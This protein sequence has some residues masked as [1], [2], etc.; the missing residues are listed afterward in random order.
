MT[1]TIRFVTL[2]CT[3][4]APMFA[5]PTLSFRT[6]YLPLGPK[7]SSVS[8]AADAVGNVFILLKVI[9]LAGNPINRV[10]KTDATGS[11]MTHFDFAEGVT[12]TAISIDP[13]GNVLV[14]G[15]GL[16]AR[17][18]NNLTTVMNMSTN[19]GSA[20]AVTTDA[21]GNVYIAGNAFAGFPT[22]PGSYQPTGNPAPI[23]AFVAK[24]STDLGTI[25]YATLF[26]G[27]AP[28][29]YQTSSFCRL[30]PVQTSANSVA[31]GPDGSVVIAGNT[32]AG[33]TPIMSEEGPYT[34]GFVAKFSPDLS[35][36]LGGVS[37]ASGSQGP[38]PTLGSI[39]YGP[40]GS[41]SSFYG[42][43]I[44]TEGDVVLSG[45]AEFNAAVSPA[46]TI[47]PLPPLGLGLAALFLV[48]LDPGFNYLW[49]TFFGGNAGN[50]IQL[51]LDPSGNVWISG[52]AQIGTLPG[53]APAPMANVAEYIPFVAE[54]TAD[55]QSVLNLESSAFGGGPIAAAPFGAAV[56][57]SASAPDSFLLTAAPDQPSLLMVAN[58]ANNQSSGTIAP[59]ELISLFGAGIGPESPLDGRV[60]NGA[61]TKGL[62]GYQVLFNGVPAPLLYAGP[63]QINVVS[64]AEISSQSS[65]DIEVVGP[66]GTTA[67]PTVF[68]AAV[69]P[70]IF[71]QLNLVP[72][73]P[74]PGFYEARYVATAY[75]QD[76]TLNSVSNPAPAGS[77]VTIWA[78][79]TGMLTSEVADGQIAASAT[80]LS[81]PGAMPTTSIQFQGQAPAAVQGLTQI[82]FTVPT[83][84]GYML[85]TD[86]HQAGYMAEAFIWV[87]R[88]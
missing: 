54:L 36:V 82:N 25:L 10:L 26:G 57:G 9:D 31:V 87:S 46:G 33:T 67:F 52:N 2:L 86:F 73:T 35:S 88:D 48:K 59:M 14:V 27:A 69:S 32:D 12:L 66:L 47:Q 81:Q 53:A 8:V 13:Q 84:F 85:A 75:N 55:G 34:Y 5:D 20:N 16:V 80:A 37:M 68:V 15:G 42:V 11:I 63:N 76:G 78:T 72:P 51:A 28:D 41:P 79:G 44:D 39:S 43:A 6:H 4:L 49:G 17:L 50:P 7:D 40:A 74:V 24:L 71:S 3:I 30:P 56:L 1:I 21:A 58:S 23:Y 65:V 19:P 22:T 62:G 18:D 61:F 60:V 64:P 83:N 38:F 29:C 45:W 70:Q 77:I